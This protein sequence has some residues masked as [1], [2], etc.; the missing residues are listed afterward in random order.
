VWPIVTQF[1]T[2]KGGCGVFVTINE[3]DLK[4]R[5]KANVVRARALFA[6]AD[7]AEQTRRCVETIRATGA[8]PTMYVM[9]SPGKIHPYWCCD[10]IPLD[11]FTALQKALADRLDTDTAPTDL[12]RVMRLP[13]TDH[14]KDPAAP[15]RVTLGNNAGPRWKV[16]DLIQKLGLSVGRVAPPNPGTNPSPKSKQSPFEDPTAFTNTTASTETVQDTLGTDI[17][18]RKINLDACRA[19]CPL[20]DDAIN[21]GGKDHNQPL[22]SRLALLTTFTEGGSADLHRMSNQH[23]GYDP[24][25]T[26]ALYGRKVSEQQDGK[27]GWP[28]CKA[29]DNA[30]CK[31]CKSCSHLVEGKSPLNFELLEKSQGRNCSPLFTPIRR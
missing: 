12:P 1:N 18:Q 2:S 5:K 30:G 15:F 16:A 7:D 11:Q 27:I 8:R 14:L 31:Q 22:W 25:K 3:T 26:D 13:G 20:I 21:N 24:D 17:E 29:L 19:E 9:T 6:D 23:S 4:G 10:D 28:S